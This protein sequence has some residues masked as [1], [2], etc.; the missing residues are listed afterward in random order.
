MD[1]GVTLEHEGEESESHAAQVARAA[2][3]E[4]AQCT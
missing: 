2:G 4:H 1:E 3:E